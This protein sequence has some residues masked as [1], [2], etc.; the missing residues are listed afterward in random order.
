MCITLFLF[1]NNLL[2]DLIGKIQTFVPS[3]VKNILTVVEVIVTW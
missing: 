3:G 2:Q 1:L